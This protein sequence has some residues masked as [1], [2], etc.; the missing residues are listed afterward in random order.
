ML[1]VEPTY[2]AGW[3]IPGGYVEIGESPRTA[4]V[5]EVKE[6]LGLAIDV[7]GPS[8]VDWAP[9]PDEGDK[10]LILF[11]GGSL[12]SEQTA[13]IHVRTEEIAETRYASSDELPG[14]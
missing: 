14:L 6:E 10:I 5:R 1:V 3:D 11:R 4:A 12:T 2:K 13:A 7:D 8:A 9:H